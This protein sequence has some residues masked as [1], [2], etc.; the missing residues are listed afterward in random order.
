MINKTKGITLFGLVILF[1]SAIGVHVTEE[2]VESMK[3][4]MSTD[5]SEI[6]E[7]FHKMMDVLEHQRCVN[8]HPSDNVPKQADDRYPHHLGITR[9]NGEGSATNC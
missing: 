9:T 8:C 2:P 6:D 1:F 5:I 4:E 7:A 3:P